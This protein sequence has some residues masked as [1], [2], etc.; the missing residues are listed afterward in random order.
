MRLKKTILYSITLIVIIEFLLR[1]IGFG[2]PILYEANKENYYP[3]S[4]QELRRYMGVKLNINNTG[5][6]TNYNWDKMNVNKVVFFGDS[7]TFGGSYIDNKD[8]FSEKY[9]EYLENAICGNY[10]V[11]G[12]KLQN[13]N[14]RLKETK[15]FKNYD[16]LIIIVSNS[17]TN[18][19]SN[20]YTYP[21][22]NKKDYLIL[23]SILEIINHI[24]FNYKIMDRY[25][26]VGLYQEA[27]DRDL[28]EKFKNYLENFKMIIKLHKHTKKIHIFILPTLENLN[29]IVDPEN[30]LE[31]ID[32]DDINVI[33]LYNQM[34]NLDYTKIYHDNAHLNK[35]GHALLAKMI[36]DNIK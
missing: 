20:F 27:T 14:S 32:L 8:L 3:S 25:H 15:D 6:R 19:K 21:F 35:K 33:N 10:A 13:L 4:N 26:G 22:Y 18:G 31:Q 17:F 36:Y 12:Y 24:L 9:C 1:Y 34:K 30:F 28:S 23:S 5:M 11:N 16:S 29:G 7:V 2:N